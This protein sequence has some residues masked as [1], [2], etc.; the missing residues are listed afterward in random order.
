M[1]VEIVSDRENLLFSRREV[2]L[3]GEFDSAPSKEESRK[4]VADK[5]KSDLELVRIQKI[6]GKFG[7]RVFRIIA[8]IYSSKE[9][10]ERLVKKTKKELDDEKK[11]E[12]ARKAA[13]EE[14]RKKAEEEAKAKEEAEK[15]A[16]EEKKEEAEKAPEGVPS[17]SEA[18]S[19]EKK[20]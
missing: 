10:F 17:N 5:F 2:I 6:E 18:E 3:A 1:S 7:T 12:E 8:D 9:E 16:V 14:A 4:I 19:K 13:E 11:A 20:E 15:A